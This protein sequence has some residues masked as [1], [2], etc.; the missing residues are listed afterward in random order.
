VGLL[1]RQ[2]GREKRQDPAPSNGAIEFT[3]EL[4]GIEYIDITNG[5]ESCGETIKEEWRPLG[6]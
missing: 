3:I 4:I 5:I 6:S 2:V 1:P